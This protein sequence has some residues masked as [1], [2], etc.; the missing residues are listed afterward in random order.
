MAFYS[1]TL[2]YMDMVEPYHLEMI[3][4]KFGHVQSI[5]DPPYR[6][7]EAHRGPSALKY[8]VKYGFQ[9][10]NW[11]CWRNHLFPKVHGEKAQFEFL[12]IP[13]YL[14]WFLNVSHL[15]IANRSH[16]DEDMVVTTIVDNELLERNR[17]VLDATLRWMYYSPELCTFESVRKMASD[18]VNFLSGMSLGPTTT[19]TTTTT[20]AGTTAAPPTHQPLPKQALGSLN[21]ITLLHIPPWLM[22]YHHWSML[23]PQR[24][25]LANN[26]RGRI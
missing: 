26:K 19:T 6:P 20:A 4:R 15:V 16:E 7:L 1:G 22:L 25:C 5:L 2:K 24:E 8:S 13:D 21:M 12:A 18:V 23:A 17:H 9:Q 3:L 11:E 10:D 14:P